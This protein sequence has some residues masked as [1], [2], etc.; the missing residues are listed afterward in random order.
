MT[1][2]ACLETYERLQQPR[3]LDTG[4]LDEVSGKAG[5]S[6]TTPASGPRNPDHWSSAT[7]GVSANSAKPRA[8]E[9]L[10]IG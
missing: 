10:V 6:A 3:A 4:L 2:L 8:R 9:N 5:S 7:R 1:E